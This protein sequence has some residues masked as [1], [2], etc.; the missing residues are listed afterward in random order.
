MYVALFTARIAWQC[1]TLSFLIVN[2]F[3]KY[4]TIESSLVTA[5]L[6]SALV[7]ALLSHKHVLVAERVPSNRLA[8]IFY[9]LSPFSWPE[10]SKGYRVISGAI[11]AVL[12]AAH[13]VRMWG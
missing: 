3:I 13:V 1:F 8:A 4:P 5:I 9:K 2:R 7:D 6:L 10:P 11:I 12:L